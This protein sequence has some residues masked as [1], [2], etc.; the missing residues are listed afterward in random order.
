MHPDYKFNVI[1]HFRNIP[2]NYKVLFLQGG[3]T[4]EMAAI[5]LNLMGLKEN[6][7][8]DYVVT[9]TWSQKAAKEAQKYG[10]VNMVL[11]KLESYTSEYTLNTGILFENGGSHSEWDCHPGPFK[12]FQSV[13][14]YSS[15]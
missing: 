5:P 12:I 10:K 11:P 4:G 6:G 14:L 3:G 2:D 7:V 13:K 9:G 8:A 1:Y 15:M